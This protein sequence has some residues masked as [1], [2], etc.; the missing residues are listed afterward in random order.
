MKINIYLQVWFEE[1]VKGQ[2]LEISS[3]LIF[4]KCLSYFIY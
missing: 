4:A 3:W 2:V 1:L